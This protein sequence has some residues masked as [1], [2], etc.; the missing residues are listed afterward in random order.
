MVIRN[1]AANL[2]G[3]LLYPLLAL[4]LVPFYIGR[5][6]LEG[7]GFIGL[8]ALTLSLLGVFSRGLGGALQR[9]VSR[10]T[11][12]AEA[13]TLRTLLRSME[14][15]YWGAA[16]LLASATAVL[17]V[18][19][20][21]RWLAPAT[22]SP[23]TVTACLLLLALRVALAFPHSVYQ[24]MLTGAERQVLGAGLNAA[25]ALTAAAA[26]V[27]A[28]LVYDSVVAV[29]AAEAVT[30][31]VFLAVFRQAAYRILPPAP[32]R[33]DRAEITG[34]AR[35]SLALMWTS[36]AG[37]LIANL[38]R[39]FVTALLPV[40]ALAVY[41]IA[42]MGGRVV[43]LFANPFL[44]ASYPGT[45]R[46]AAGG[47]PDAQAANL[48]RNA[49]AI[50]VIVAAVGVPLSGFS[51]EALALWVRDD[52][53]VAQGAPLMSLYV[54]GSLLVT[55]AS[56]LYQWQTATGR[57]RT[58]VLFNLAA[59]AWF[60]P[61]LWMAVSRWGLVGAAASWTLYGALA[62]LVNVG[63]TFG[64]RALPARWLGAYLGMTAGALAPALLVTAAARLAADQWLGDALLGRVACGAAAGLA[65][66]AAALA[67][68]APRLGADGF[69]G[70]FVKIAAGR[71]GRK[72]Y[73]T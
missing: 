30:A 26:G 45:C 15:L 27:A 8:M 10:R 36:G 47:S 24:S 39:L 71:I 17:A 1:T 53:V 66:G 16:L 48:L 20:A 6:G 19:T 54:A 29:Y 12:S 67:V 38:D 59:M 73:N 32:A 7:Y 43:T 2:A 52:R 69:P 62:W 64:R 65:G 3:Q 5:L 18:T 50:V 61:V 31:G 23:S 33:I 46:V 9:E 28:V 70:Q 37:L 21:G 35:I 4:A 40:A 56:V 63:A 44:M 41:T 55:T 51:A 68:V 13:A 60:P 42:V 49:A 11:G 14:V 57:T 58:A 25:L 72:I 22:L 34:L